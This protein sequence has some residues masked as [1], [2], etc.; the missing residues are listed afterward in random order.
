MA[1]LRPVL[2]PLYLF[3]WTLLVGGIGILSS[4]SIAIDDLSSG[5]TMLQDIVFFMGILYAPTKCTMNVH[6]LQHFAYYVSKRGPIWAYSC[7]AFEGMNAFIKPLKLKGKA[8]CVCDKLE[9]TFDNVRFNKRDCAASLRSLSVSD[10]DRNRVSAILQR[11]HD[12]PLVNHHVYLKPR[13]GGPVIIYVE[14]IQRKCV[15]IDISTDA[16]IIS[17]F[18]NIIEHN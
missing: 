2:N 11:Y 10:D 5:D 15:F 12:K 6:L 13:F 7:F 18:P 3:H 1:V 4:D 17:R 9:E 14:Q 16:R 8:I